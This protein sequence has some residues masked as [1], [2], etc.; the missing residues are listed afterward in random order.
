M[1]QKALVICDDIYLPFGEIRIRQSG[2][3][4]GH[5]GLNSIIYE[6]NS[7]DFNRM[8]I[9]VGQPQDKEILKQY[10]L[11]DFD[12]EEQKKITTIADFTN[13]LIECFITEGFQS[14]I[15][16][17]SKNKKSYSEKEK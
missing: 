4:G 5:N 7:E 14:M 2:G 3:D 9:G 10:V 12:T 15:N 6:L 16:N 8:R 17:Y 11:E 13:K 1:T